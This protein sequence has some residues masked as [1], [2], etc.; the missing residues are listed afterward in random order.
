MQHAQSGTSSPA[1]I[2][3]P[4]PNAVPGAQVSSRAA[5]VI[6]FCVA[7]AALVI[8]ADYAPQAAIGTTVV[9]GL[10]VALS[11]ASDIRQLTNTFITATGHTPLPS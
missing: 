2:A 3:A 11:H 4:A 10:G 5:K 7:G 6:G 9:I 1:S 8:L